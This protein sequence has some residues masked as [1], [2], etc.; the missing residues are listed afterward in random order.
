MET[1]KTPNPGAPF[2]AS[3]V[4]NNT[5]P[6]VL[7]NPFG[8]G[9]GCVPKGFAALQRTLADRAAM[10]AGQPIGEERSAKANPGA[11]SGATGVWDKITA[12][13]DLEAFPALQAPLNAS[14]FWNWRSNSVQPLTSWRLCWHAKHAS[15]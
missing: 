8:T 2:G 1:L 7:Q 10:I 6:S 12:Q 14:F 4:S 9:A 15:R 3:G 13:D 5:V 11:R